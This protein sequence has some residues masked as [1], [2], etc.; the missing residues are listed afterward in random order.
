[1]K[2]TN[3]VKLINTIQIVNFVNDFRVKEGRT[4]LENFTLRNKVRDIE[5]AVAISNFNSE[6]FIVEPGDSKEE[7]KYTSNSRSKPVYYVNE[8]VV[9]YLRDTATT[10]T[11]RLG[12]QKAYESIGGDP[13]VMNV[14]TRHEDLF[15]DKLH[16]L[17]SV[18]GVELEREYQILR[19]SVDFYLPEYNLVIEYDEP[20][21]ELK[22]HQIAD[23]ERQSS[24]LKHTGAETIR[25]KSTDNDTINLGKVILKLKEL[26]NKWYWY[27]EERWV[28]TSSLSGLHIKEMMSC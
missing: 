16:D 12:Y 8:E 4:I 2:N 27:I 15:S 11:D 21:H 28:D 26:D 3:E 14:M 18:L 19:F 6:D 9:R 7:I 10:T 22:E 13:M 1:M 17:M 20:H 24:I 25:L 23:E 5:K